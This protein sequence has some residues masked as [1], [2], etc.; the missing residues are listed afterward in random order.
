[1][2]ELAFHQKF[3][4]D[5]ER[6]ASLMRCITQSQVGSAKAAAECMG[7]GKPVAEGF[8]GWLFKTGLGKSDKGTYVL[9]PIGEIVADHDPHLMDSGT[10]WLLHY[11]LASQHEERAEVWYR[12]FNEFLSPGMEF[13]R[14]ELQTYIERA[15]ESAPTNRSGIADDCKE[16]VKCYTESSGLGKLQVITGAGKG[17]YQAR[18][19]QLPDPHIVAFVLFD[20]WQRRFPQ[21][22]TIRLG[23]VAQEPEMLGRVFVGGRDQV[24]QSL[25]DLQGMGWVN[26]VDSQHEPVTRRFREA[27]IQLL[28]A[29][30]TAL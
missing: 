26:L 2:R 6:L 9:S 19:G 16:L 17:T 20:S 14:G 4:L 11:Y 5:R 28:E 27:P 1:M 13:A 29:Y 3:K 21:H 22:D 8:L 15:L 7:V 25:Y 12:C 23:Q 30:Y 24:I 18:L 10:L